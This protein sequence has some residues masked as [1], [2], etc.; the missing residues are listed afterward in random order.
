[1]NTK[2]RAEAKNDFEKDFCKL[3]NNSVFRKTIEDVRKHGDI[4]LVTADNRRNQSA[5]EPNY[6][7]A[8]YFPENLIAIEMKKTKV[9]MNKIYLGMSILDISK[10]LLY[11]FWFDYIKPKYQ[12]RV[13]LCYI[14]TDLQIFILKL[15][16][17][18]KTL[19]MTLKKQFDTSNYSKDDNRPLPI[20]GNKKVIS[21]FKDELG[22]KIK[23]KFVGLRAKTWAYL[24][25]DDSEHKKAKG[26]K[27]V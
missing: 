2:L 12:D 1:M 3:M 14:D 4:N 24:L 8:K 19:P 5:S 20:G 21:L 6:H 15:K 25:D 18:M 26:T 13:K 27:S 10:T 22:G 17:F 11:E 9:K 7:A 16:I 23:R